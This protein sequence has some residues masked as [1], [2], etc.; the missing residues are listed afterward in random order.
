MK[1]LSLPFAATNEHVASLDFETTNWKGD[2]P[3]HLVWEWIDFA[4]LLL[5][6]GI[7]WQCYYQRVLSSQT[8]K[9]YWSSSMLL[10]TIKILGY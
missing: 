2:L 10:F 6:G 1:L 4:L 8:S 9:R 7:P 5:L 3:S